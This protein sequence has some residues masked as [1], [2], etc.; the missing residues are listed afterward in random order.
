VKSETRMSLKY[1]IIVCT[2]NRQNIIEICLKSICLL[3]KSGDCDF[4]VLIV[5]NNSTDATGATV[6]EFLSCLSAELQGKWHYH[7][8]RSQG[9]SHARNRGISE[10]QGE[11]LV[12][13]DDECELDKEWLTRLH[14]K[15]TI[16]SPL[17]LGG[18]YR[19]KFLPSADRSDYARGYLEKYGDS[20]HLRDR[21]PS[22]WLQKPGLSGGNMAIRRDVLQ[23]VG[24]FDPELGMSGTQMRYGEETE[25]QLRILTRYGPRSIYYSPDLLLVH[26]IRPDKTGLRTSFH[27]CVQ[28]ARNVSNLQRDARNSKKL[29]VAELFSK[30]W[31]LIRRLADLLVFLS[32]QYMQT[33]FTKGGISNPIYEA[34]QNG[35]LQACLQIG[36]TL[37]DQLGRRRP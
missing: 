13:L 8:E 37:F 27:S 17:M 19:G 30:I 22:R 32:V 18:P 36:M 34:V 23:T 24:G 15:I 5:D 7:L 29:S 11:W 12:F 2:Y 28:R 25:L 26:Y 6:R 4:E 3:N 31:I 9:L 14:V 10:S 33:I 20:H 1:S 21:W 35:K 16:N